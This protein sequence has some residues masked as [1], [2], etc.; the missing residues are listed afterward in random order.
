MCLSPALAIPRHAPR[1]QMLVMLVGSSHHQQA[2]PQL[3]EGSSGNRKQTDQEAPCGCSSVDTQGAVL[4]VLNSS[5]DSHIIEAPAKHLS[6]SRT[7]TELIK[8]LPLCPM[9]R[10]DPDVQF[11]ISESGPIDMSPI[12][13]CLSA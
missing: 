5:E 8:P 6:T 13:I 10:T 11:L 2:Y 1:P 7:E 9:K 3:V 4:W 12:T